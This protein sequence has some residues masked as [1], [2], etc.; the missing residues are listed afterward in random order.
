[1]AYSPRGRKES[2]TTERLH[3]H[4]CPQG[5]VMLFKKAK[6]FRFKLLIVTINVLN[7]EMENGKT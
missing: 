6:L 7:A 1:M 2:D 4:F 5:P 3:F